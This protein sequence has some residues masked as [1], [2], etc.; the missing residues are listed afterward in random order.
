MHQY[1]VDIFFHILVLQEYW[2][3][4]ESRI[5]LTPVLRTLEMLHFPLV[6]MNMVNKTKSSVHVLDC[7]DS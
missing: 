3:L 6:P 4:A 7:I 2:D 5:P 1:S